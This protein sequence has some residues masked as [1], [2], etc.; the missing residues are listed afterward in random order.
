MAG[1]FDR[2]FRDG[3]ASRQIITAPGGKSFVIIPRDYHLAEVDDFIDKPRSLHASITM[4]TAEAFQNYVNRHGTHDSMIFCD[5][6][7]PGFTAVID[8]HGAENAPTNR[9]HKVVFNPAL[10][11]EW[12]FWAA[13][14]GK[15]IAQADFV[16]FV[17]ERIAD[18]VKPDGASMLELAS[19]LEAKRDVA[20]K[21]GVRLADGTVQMQYIE[22]TTTSGGGAG[23]VI[24]IPTQLELGLPVFYKEDP[25][26]VRAF[27]RY[28]IHERKL[29]IKIDIHNYAQILDDAFHGIEEKVIAG[30][31]PDHAGLIVEGVVP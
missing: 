20:F 9:E 4:R 27:F 17:E 29:Q 8:W 1:V 11:E 13:I 25:Y 10:S 30:V 24:S 28:R 23:G 2:A 19:N 15:W 6:T 18:I 16:R 22:E 21:S 5:V 14:N 7:R 12:M 26:K 31:S 3:L